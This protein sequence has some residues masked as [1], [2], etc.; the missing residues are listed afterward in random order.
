MK[1]EKELYDKIWD[2]KLKKSLKK[3][4]FPTGTLRVDEAFNLIGRGDKFLDVGCGVGTLAYLVRDRF[5]DIYGVDVAEFAVKEARRVGIK[6]YAVNLNERRLPFK[7]GLFDTVSCLAVVE[8]VFEPE[9][10]ISELSR[11]TKKG[12]TLIIDTPNVR[13]LKY[14]IS[15]FFHRKFPKTSGDLERS[16][17]GGH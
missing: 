3:I 15:I 17:D 8:H 16:Y 10:L 11:V 1:V 4:K 14:L 13:Y 9:I 6:A 12:G 7:D 5:K 2:Y